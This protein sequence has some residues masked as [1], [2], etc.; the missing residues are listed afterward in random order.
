MRPLW[1][2]P[3]LLLVCAAPA[4]G[5]DDEAKPA[6]AKTYQVPYRLTA[7]Q[8]VLIRAKINGKGPF[9]FIL[10]TGAPLLF[11]STDVAKQLELHPDAD[12]WATFRFDIEGG[13]TLP[14][15]KGRIETPFQLEGMNG[16]GLA[17]V[18]LHGMIGYN[19]LARFRLEFDFTKHKMGWTPLDFEP[20]MP[21]RINVEGGTPGG[22]DALGT[23]MKFMGALMGKKPQPE[24]APRGFLGAELAEGDEAVEV[25]KVLSRSPAERAGLKAGDQITRFQDK[26]VAS[27][28]TL[29]RLAAG[30]TPGQSARLTVT[31]GTASHQINVELGEGL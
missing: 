4:L 8:H 1:L 29:E 3:G 9:N 6:R 30:L 19:I 14:K 10:D 13:V 7:M 23:I 12:G 11:V 26:P 5:A 18:Q 25:K 16:L 2:F 20:P 28:K 24:F 17:G 21:K 31:R 15:A 27:L 22:L